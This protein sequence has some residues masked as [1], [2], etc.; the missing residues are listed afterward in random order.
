[1]LWL[2]LFARGNYCVVFD[3]AGHV[4]C[5]VFTCSRGGLGGADEA[6]VEIIGWF[7]FVCEKLLVVV[8]GR[9]LLHITHILLVCLLGIR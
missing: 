9:C 4:V 8:L 6:A 1:M 7:S 2:L 3:A 5:E